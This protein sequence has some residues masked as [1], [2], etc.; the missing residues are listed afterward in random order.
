MHD[1]KIIDADT[2]S[3]YA[4]VFGQLAGWSE[5]NG[6]WSIELFTRDGAVRFTSSNP[7][8]APTVSRVAE[9]LRGDCGL[10]NP[11]QAVMI[12][13]GCLLIEDE[14]R[15][16]LA[17]FREGECVESLTVVL[18]ARNIHSL[19]EDFFKT[20]LALQ[21]AIE[22]VAARGGAQLLAEAD[23]FRLN[24]GTLIE[25]APRL[26]PEDLAVLARV[27]FIREQLPDES[28]A[29][30]ALFAR[31][32]DSLSRLS[33]LKLEFTR[34]QEV[35]FVSHAFGMLENEVVD[36]SLEFELFFLRQP[37]TTTALLQVT[38]ED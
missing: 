14:R 9:I 26:H 13:N 20:E 21:D 29:M 37:W 4:P 32:A 18:A 5:E 16:L 1:V 35:G 15:G 27:L 10:E 28:D 8:S 34:G 31:F 3:Q 30:E 38:L 11:N 25:W 17:D 24:D 2:H 7:D 19:V 23:Q 33:A 6:R 22:Q 12:R 36:T